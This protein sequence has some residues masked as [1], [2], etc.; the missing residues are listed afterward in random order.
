MTAR[1]ESCL[2]REVYQIQSCPLKRGQRKCENGAL[3]FVRTAYRM[4]V[5]ANL[6]DVPKLVISGKAQAQERTVVG[7]QRYSL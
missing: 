1:A 3:S 2:P 5:V 4:A 6:E 7:E